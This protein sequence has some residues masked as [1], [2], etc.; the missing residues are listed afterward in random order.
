MTPTRVRLQTQA[1]ICLASRET[2]PGSTRSSDV[3][4]VPYPLVGD[5]SLEVVGIRN[6]HNGGHMMCKN[7]KPVLA[8]GLPQEEHWHRLPRQ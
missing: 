7:F 2:S 3:F 1:D 6:E 8:L 4:T 5:A